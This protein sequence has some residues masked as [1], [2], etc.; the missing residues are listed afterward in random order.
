MLLDGIFDCLI[1]DD[2]I[3]IV[4]DGDFGNGFVVDGLGN[5]IYNISIDVSYLSIDFLDCLGIII[6]E[7]N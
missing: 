1:F 6:V 4:V 2:F 3:I 7:D 5:F